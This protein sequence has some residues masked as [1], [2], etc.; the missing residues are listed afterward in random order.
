MT[1]KTKTTKKKLVLGRETVLYLDDKR[2]RAAIGGDDVTAHWHTERH[3]VCDCY[4]S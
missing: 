1:K 4:N 3:T 2:M